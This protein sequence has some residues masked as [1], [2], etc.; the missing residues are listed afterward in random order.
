MAKNPFDVA[1]K[2]QSQINAN[3]PTT[4][5]HDAYVSNAK[6]KGVNLKPVP[7]VTQPKQ[8]G[9]SFFDAFDIPKTIMRQTEFM[10]EDKQ[11][12]VI[13]IDP[14]KI[15][16]EDTNWFK[17]NITKSAMY[18]GLDEKAALVR[19]KYDRVLRVFPD[20]ITQDDFNDFQE[21]LDPNVLNNLIQPMQDQSKGFDELRQDKAAIGA[22]RAVGQPRGNQILGDG[23]GEFAGDRTANIERESQ[24]QQ[25][26]DSIVPMGEQAIKI[27]TKAFDLGQKVVEE[28]PVVGLV[29]NILMGKGRP[30][31]IRTVRNVIEK[32]SG[33]ESNATIPSLWET[34]FDTTR[35][36][37]SIPTSL[38]VGLDIGNN[39]MAA[40]G[41]VMALVSPIVPGA[42]TIKG[43]AKADDMFKIINAF[44]K[45]GNSAKAINAGAD[46]NTIKRM[47]RIERALTPAQK[48]LALGTIKSTGKDG[49]AKA[50]DDIMGNAPKVVENTPEAESRA[51][52]AV[53]ARSGGEAETILTKEAVAAQG[54]QQGLRDADEAL[55]WAYK[56]FPDEMMSKGT[57]RSG[58]VVEDVFN[59]EGRMD[60]AP[61]TRKSVEAEI[62]EDISKEAPKA[63]GTATPDIKMG[64]G[65]VLFRGGP[66]ISPNAIKYVWEGAKYGYEFPFKLAS[67]VW[68]K[69]LS[70]V[71][72][73]LDWGV[74]NGLISAAEAR[75]RR[76]V[77]NN[78][79]QDTMLGKFFRT[80]VAP[81]AYSNQIVARTR[82]ARNIGFRHFM[83]N[84]ADPLYRQIEN[85]EM[86]MR[87]FEAVDGKR[88]IA[89]LTV[90][91][92]TLHDDFVMIRDKMTDDALKDLLLNPN[93]IRDNYIRY[94]YDQ[95]ENKSLFKRMRGGKDDLR[96]GFD[97]QNQRLPELSDAEALNIKAHY[98]LNSVFRQGFNTELKEQMIREL[99]SGE[100]VLS[101]ATK[102]DAI[103]EYMM[104][105]G[106]SQEDAVRVIQEHKRG[107]KGNYIFQEARK[108]VA[109]VER[110]VLKENISPLSEKQSELLKRGISQNKKFWEKGKYMTPEW[111]EE[112]LI[113]S[114]EAGIRGLSE[115]S[116]DLITARHMNAMFNDGDINKLATVWNDL[117]PRVELS[118][119]TSKLFLSDS[120]LLE[121]SRTLGKMKAANSAPEKIAAQ[122]RHVDGL[123]AL[124]EAN[125]K[126]ADDSSY[127]KIPD[128]SMYGP[129]RNMYV[130]RSVKMDIDATIGA[131]DMGERMLDLISKWTLYR[132]WKT[133]K[134]VWNPS[135]HARN[136]MWNA[137]ST[138]TLADV[139]PLDFKLW[140]NTINQMLD[141]D[142]DLF[143]LM[144]DTGV[145]ES[146]FGSD[147]KSYITKMERVIAAEK[148]MKG[149][150]G[151]SAM[152]KTT[153]DEGVGKSLLKGAKATIDIPARVYGGEEALFKAL[154]INSEIEKAGGWS[155]VKAMME[156]GDYT[157]A[158]AAVKKAQEFLFDYSDASPLLNA[159]TKTPFFGSPFAKFYAK[160]GPMF[161][162][163][164]ARNPHRAL[165]PL[166]MGA[167][168]QY[169]A[170]KKYGKETLKES[171]EALPDWVRVDFPWVGDYVK[172]SV[173]VGGEQGDPNSITWWDWTNILPYV[174]NMSMVFSDYYR[175]VGMVQAA[176]SSSNPFSP[177]NAPLIRAA[178]DIGYNRD[179]RN[180]DI[181]PD[182]G[183]INGSPRNRKAFKEY[184]YR[185]LMPSLMPES[186]GS[187]ETGPGGYGATRIERAK[188]GRIDPVTG[189]QRSIKE[190]RLKTYAG[191]DLSHA[192]VEK[193]KI[194]S[195][196]E[197]KKE[198]ENIKKDMKY[199][200][201][202][203]LQTKTE[204]E[205]REMYE[206]DMESLREINK[207]L[208]RRGG[209][210]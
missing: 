135:T 196:Y 189:T 99:S 103:A 61:S 119:Q 29:P 140:G 210:R 165:F 100:K 57:G 109:E 163:Q 1:S 79:D 43:A 30:G 190:A 70:K 201:L 74:S 56:N 160:F 78:V 39:R 188:Q 6:S 4:L 159:F 132:T 93:Q 129:M 76:L 164:L 117:F 86:S 62:A 145:F 206:A 134:T 45:F 55:E 38:N 32:L 147:V 14:K 199:K 88:D 104:S 195:M 97:W 81:S 68:L 22:Q 33:E 9:V 3:K 71:D 193:Y 181:M 151:W 179:F 156:N 101:D 138:W 124:R 26:E 144:Q 203:A 178:A 7:E 110:K 169:A 112:H 118:P 87:V 8:G 37:D 11:G 127:V 44:D 18:K 21:L 48:E 197:L 198:M 172:A 126:L 131:P 114:M 187:V 194:Y 175:G 154:I 128:Q 122:Q 2:V 36:Y 12:R 59:L 73:K 83:E 106:V 50:Y 123:T 192:N 19:D 47:Q 90:K 77:I 204:K 166:A 150:S 46:L 184:I 161:A 35:E 66:D 92:K 91:E 168:I 60:I 148:T 107:V 170:G 23:S 152:L 17:E 15:T 54:T 171:Y 183:G 177:I 41:F 49:I 108:F 72:A 116:Y 146:G 28:I 65:D 125:A 142:S 180:Q 120:H 191:I 121:E 98:E 139:N 113:K 16:D 209:K 174:D 102:R 80:T 130:K 202:N 58:G 149:G 111:K 105:R 185:L 186:I 75:T 67:K 82:M 115:F 162:K 42:A 64:S 40:M 94:Y 158:Q 167:G 52:Q 141:K 51:A 63:K 153:L 207:E 182:K 13:K 89:T 84:V 34:A 208:S 143:K 24:R 27:V 85:D 10:V 31:Q 157:A 96:M 5:V 137:I 176:T 136:I 69:G 205:A 155:A 20:H 173:P 133:S 25:Y 53:V 200:Y 95:Y